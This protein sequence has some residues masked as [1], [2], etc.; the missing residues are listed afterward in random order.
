MSEKMNEYAALLKEKS[1][2]EKKMELIKE[3]AEQEFQK[4]VLDEGNFTKLVDGVI[5]SKNKG[6]TTYTYSPA[7]QAQEAE[8][9]ALKQRERDAGTAQSSVS[10]KCIFS[11]K[12]S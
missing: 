6:K 2:L 9:K 10:I 12:V 5:F 1:A 3:Q 11:A 7:V 8:L 4:E